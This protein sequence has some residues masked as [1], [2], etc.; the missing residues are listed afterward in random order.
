VTVETLGARLEAAG[1]GCAPLTLHGKESG[2]CTVRTEPVTIDTYHTELALASARAQDGALACQLAF[3][4]TPVR[5]VGVV[6]QSERWTVKVT[7][8][9]VAHEVADALGG[10]VWSIDSTTAC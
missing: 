7:T 1:L 8:D 2:T 5:S 9:A 4:G 6:N 3:D 10:V